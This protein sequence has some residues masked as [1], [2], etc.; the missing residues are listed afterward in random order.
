MARLQRKAISDTS[1]TAGPR[2]LDPAHLADAK[3]AKI[4]CAAFGAKRRAR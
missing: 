3:G 2:A 1:A 4:T